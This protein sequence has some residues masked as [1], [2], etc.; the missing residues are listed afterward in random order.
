MDNK[1]KTII[2]LGLH[3][4]QDAAMYIKQGY[5]VFAVDANPTLIEK[6][7]RRLDT[8]RCTL[9]NTGISNEDAGPFDFFVNK[10]RSEWSGFIEHSKKGGKYDV[11]S[12]PVI[13]VETLFRKYINLERHSIVKPVPE[14]TAG[15]VKNHQL[16]TVQ[17]TVR[18]LNPVVNAK[19]V[20][21]IKLPK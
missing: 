2:D 6:A 7:E 1:I 11:I 18:G 15:M 17:A 19:V 14:I 16:K 13:S 12:V 4:A 9:I 3:E 10:T 20:A 5:F 8:S 21:A